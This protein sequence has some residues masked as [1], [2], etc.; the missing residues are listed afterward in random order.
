M[1]AVYRFSEVW[2]GQGHPG[3]MIRLP[4]SPLLVPRDGPYR[5]FQLDPLEVKD[6]GFNFGQI[7]EV[8]RKFFAGVN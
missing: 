2:S 8:E 7:L 3:R 5:K 4:N 6:P 1:E